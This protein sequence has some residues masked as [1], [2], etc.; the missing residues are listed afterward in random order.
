MKFASNTA[1]ATKLEEVNMFPTTTTTT[2]YYVV[3]VCKTPSLASTV[4]LEKYLVLF[5]ATSVVRLVHPDC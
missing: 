4:D 1:V 2:M 5:T 3:V